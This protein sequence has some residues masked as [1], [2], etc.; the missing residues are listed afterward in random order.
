[1]NFL[2][3]LQENALTSVNILSGGARDL[4]FYRTGVYNLNR[5]MNMSAFDLNDA[6]NEQEVSF[7]TKRSSTMH[8]GKQYFIVIAQYFLKFFCFI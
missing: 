4:T 8:I 3:Y 7:F 2:N 6:V 5:E 1:M